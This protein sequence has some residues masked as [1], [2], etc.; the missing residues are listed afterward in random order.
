MPC[1]PAFAILGYPVISFANE[2]IAHK[3]SRNSLLGA[4]V[5]AELFRS[6]SAELQVTERTPPTFF[7]HAKDDGGVGPK[8]SLVLAQA[9]KAAGVEAEVYLVNRG[10]HGF[11]MRLDEW[12]EPCAQWLGRMGAISPASAKVELEIRGHNFETGILS[13]GVR[14]FGNRRYVF[15]HVLEDFWGWQFTR[16]NGGQRSCLRVVAKT[17]MTIYAATST[18]RQPIDMTGWTPR[19]GTYLQYTDGGH[20]KMPVFTQELKA[21]EEI[22]LPEGSWTGVMIMAPRMKIAVIDRHPEYRCVPGVVIDHVPASTGTYVGSPSIV[23]LP[24]GAYLASHDLFGGRSGADKIGRTPVF[25]SE[26]RGQTWR[27]LTEIQ[28]QFWSTLFVHRGDVYLMGTN[29]RHGSVSVRRSSDRGETWTEP[30]DEDHGLLLTGAKYHCAPMPVVIHAG[31]IW[32]AMEDTMGPGGWGHHFRAFMMSAPV[33]VDLLKAT[34]WTCSNRLGRD[35]S[36]LDGRFGGWLEG[37]AVATPDGQM[38]NILRVDDRKLGGQ[39]AVIR[40]SE[41]GRVATFDPTDG[42]VDFPGANSKFT[43]RF[44]PESRLYW[45]LTNYVPSL[46]EGR[47]KGGIRNTLALIASPD[48]VHWEVR[49]VPLFHPDPSKHAFQYPDWQFDGDDI[50]VASRTAYDDGLGGAH[51]F[52]DANYLTFHR[53]RRFRELTL[54]DAHPLFKLYAGC[55]AD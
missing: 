16:L 39:A 11:G 12:M 26:D 18:S 21:N 53:I 28:G 14:A 24:D 15:E 2:D 19:S 9:L 54:K 48:L 37:N 30:A 32:R 23:A 5:E 6:L 36:W 43:L 20:T 41:A 1:R 25:R 51:S 52:H 49:A 27:K 22:R 17:D 35:P 7:F 10:G 33:D 42:F 29:S 44:D 3:G 8:N 38:V 55:S 31:R 50:I 4:K 46:Y 13:K 40:I 45:S 34:S 47:N